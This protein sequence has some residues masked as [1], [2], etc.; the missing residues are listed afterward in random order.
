M[1]T[2]DELQR[3][4]QSFKFRICENSEIRSSRFWSESVELVHNMMV[5]ASSRSHFRLS[6]THGG[7]QICTIEYPGEA[8]QPLC[9]DCSYRKFCKLPEM[10]TAVFIKS[11]VS[12]D[13]PADHPQYETI[14]SVFKLLHGKSKKVVLKNVH[15]SQHVLSL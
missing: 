12:I 3:L 4:K 9:R 8:G 6:D 13:D 11:I 10:Q 2:R 5:W 14:L 7:W 15:G 1:I